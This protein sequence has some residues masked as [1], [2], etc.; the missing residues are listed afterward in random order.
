LELTDVNSKP[1]RVP[2]DDV[3]EGSTEYHGKFAA[4]YSFSVGEVARFELEPQLSASLAVQTER[5]QRIAQ[6]T[7]ELALKSALLEQAEAN[8]AE[9]ADR[10]L[11]QTSLVEQRD[12]ELVDMQAK[13]DQLAVSRDQQVGQYEKELTNV[14]AKLEAKESAESTAFRL[15]LADMKNDC[16]ESK[17]EADIYR[18]QT[19]TDLINTDEDRVV[20]RLM[21]RVQAMEAEMASLRWNEKG[22][23]MMECR[24]EG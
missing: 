17:A 4:P 15:R 5:D 1:R 9:A 3:S 18:N 21:E 2:E 11:T 13:L 24:N 20:H 8:A 16:G 22:F 6:L 10:I 7:D 12:V 19:A 23:D 14:R